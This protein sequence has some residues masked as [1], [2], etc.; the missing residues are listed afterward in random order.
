MARR[1]R[2]PMPPKPSPLKVAIVRALEAGPM[3]IAE[4]AEAVGRDPHLLAQP[5]HAMRLQGLVE[6][7]PT[8]P[9]CVGRG[10]HRVIYT[11]IKT[12]YSQE[13]PGMGDKDKSESKPPYPSKEAEECEKDVRNEP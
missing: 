6:S 10:G 1:E 11:L 8:G 9:R 3:T 13:D 2:A 5:L 7:T 4:L 12:P